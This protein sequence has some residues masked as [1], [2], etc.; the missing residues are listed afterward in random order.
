VVAFNRDDMLAKTKR[1][2]V[3]A[4]LPEAMVPWPTPEESISMLVGIS[5]FL[6]L[7]LSG[8]ADASATGSR[9]GGK[10]AEAL[11]LGCVSITAGAVVPLRDDKFFCSAASAPL[12]IA[13]S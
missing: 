3:I 13:A 9:T 12:E 11:A 5:R 7:V 4:S 1:Q 8:L 2:G 10:G 6:G